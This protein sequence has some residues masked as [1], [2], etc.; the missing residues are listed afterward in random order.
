MDSRKELLRKKVKDAWET[1]QLYKR[2]YGDDAEDTAD[3]REYWLGLQDA[4]DT[5]FEGEE[6]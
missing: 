4:W 2:L 6:V 1:L 5:L 3:I